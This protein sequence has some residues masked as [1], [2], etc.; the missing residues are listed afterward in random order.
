MTT[1]PLHWAAEHPVPTA[2][3]VF[4][5]GALLLIVMGAGKGGGGSQAGAGMS[6]FYAAQAVQSA[7]NASVATTQSNN[8]AAMGIAKIQADASTAINSNNNSTAVTLNQSNNDLTAYQTYK[9]TRLETQKSAW[10]YYLDVTGAP[11]ASF[12]ADQMDA[13]SH[14]LTFGSS[15]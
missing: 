3:G 12:F 4:A 5:V 13:I 2:V 15:H 6:S 7:N 9:Q 14:K 10:G 1:H 8:S 11:G